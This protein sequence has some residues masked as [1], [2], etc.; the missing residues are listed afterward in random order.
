M[1]TG[2]N[3]L[4]QKGITE[5]EFSK[6]GLAY[7]TPDG[8]FYGI[9]SSPLFQRAI[10]ICSQFLNENKEFDALQFYGDSIIVP[11]QD[12][13]DNIVSLAF[14]KLS[15][16]APCKF[17]GIRGFKK[18]SVLFGLNNAYNSILE[19]DEVFLVEGYWEVIIL[20][21]FGI[22]NVVALCGLVS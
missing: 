10:K 2:L 13:Y 19:K 4:Y 17:L 12:A 9:N 11:I 6:F 5:N 18:T 8:A 1:I 14:R 15:G 22:N 16:G 7:L 3:Y 20:H 21:K